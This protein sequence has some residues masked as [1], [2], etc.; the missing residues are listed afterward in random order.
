ME[1][2]AQAFSSLFWSETDDDLAGRD[3]LDANTLSLV[4][5]F[6]RGTG[7][8][9]ADNIYHK[10]HTIL[11][12][13]TLSLNLSDGSIH[14]KLG[15]SLVYARMKALAI[16]AIW[17]S[18]AIRVDLAVAASPLAAWFDEPGYMLP[19]VANGGLILVGPGALAFPVTAGLTDAVA[20]TA[21]GGDAVIDIAIL[22]ASA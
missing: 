1:F 15:R 4:R 21:V 2:T 19:I 9:Q 17:D 8:D 7:A 16:S 6:T 22:G 18:E 11:Q 12:D 14:N 13:S 10:R 20:L 5:V 3:G